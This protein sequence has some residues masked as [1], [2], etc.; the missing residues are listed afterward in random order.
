M[1]EERSGTAAAA[2]DLLNRV[3]A[4]DS[5]AA[6]RLGDMLPSLREAA[7]SGDVAAQN[8][9]GG[10]LLG[11]AESPS[12]AALW[13]TKAAERGSAVG[14]RSLGHLY[15]NGL[16]VPQDLAQ[17]ERLFTE[18]A[19]Q[20]DAH[21]Q[22]NL[23]QLR[24]GKG[25]PQAVAGLLRSAA[26]GGVDEAYAVLGDLLAAMDQDAEALRSYL[27]AAE[28]GHD[29]AMYTAACWYRDGTAGGRDKA[30]ALRW[31]FK[32]FKR[33]L[34]SRMSDRHQHL[35]LLACGR[36]V[37][38]DEHGPLPGVLEWVADRLVASGEAVLRGDVVPLPMPL[39]PGG[40]MTAL[41]AALPVCFDDEFASV[42]LENRVETSVVWLVPI[43]TAEVAFVRENGWTA[44]EEELVRQ[45]PD[46]LDLNRAEMAFE[47]DEPSQFT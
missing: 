23:A 8:V 17:A 24:W 21:A 5:A 25:D 37:P 9:L 39:I 13:F 14:K 19:D 41:Y 27:R 34:T 4:G 12:D 10:V 29:G 1:A 2:L 36:P 35:E 43:G 44:F 3:Q 7:E 38:G 11:F 16:G 30:E 18:A 40:A 32:L 6:D 31:F 33:H 45:D 28:S 42:V 47:R 15:A 22:F 46:L 20:G 26:E